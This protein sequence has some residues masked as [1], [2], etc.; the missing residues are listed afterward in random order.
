MRL[1]VLLAKLTNLSS[2]DALSLEDQQAPWTAAVPPAT[3]SLVTLQAWDDSVVPASRALR[4]PQRLAYRYTTFRTSTLHSALLYSST[5]ATQKLSE[6]DLRA[7]HARAEISFQ[8]LTADAAFKFKMFRDRHNED[9]NR[10]RS[11]LPHSPLAEKSSGRAVLY[12]STLYLIFHSKM[13]HFMSEIYKFLWFYCLRL[14][15]SKNIN[16][17]YY[18]S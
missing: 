3:Q 17:S 9:S 14:I 6:K 10:G 5:I 4:R 7:R 15:S 13:I 8:R 12:K 11:A 18:N 16:H 1:K 2:H